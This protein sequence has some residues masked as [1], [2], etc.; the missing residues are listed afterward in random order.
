M[1]P[2]EKPNSDD[3]REDVV[4]LLLWAEGQ[5]DVSRQ[6]PTPRTANPPQHWRHS[7]SLGLSLLQ[8][9]AQ[10]QQHTELLSVTASGLCSSSARSPSSSAQGAQLAAEMRPTPLHP[11]AR[12][13]CQMLTRSLCK[14]RALC[15]RDKPPSP[16][17]ARGVERRG[18]AF[19]LSFRAGTPQARPYLSAKLAREKA[20]S[21]QQNSAVLSCQPEDVVHFAE[22]PP[23]SHRTARGSQAKP[24]RKINQQPPTSPHKSTLCREVRLM[25]R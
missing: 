23:S 13:L 5:Q 25:L 18:S 2:R 9:C 4:L 3:G 11:S 17:T 1:I 14:P 15:H 21:A 7:A 6:R 20:K 8:C 24:L 16:S 12:A 19:P 22:P 10:W